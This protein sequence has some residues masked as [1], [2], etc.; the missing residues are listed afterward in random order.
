MLDIIDKM[1][2]N[3]YI[4]SSNKSDIFCI[5]CLD[6]QLFRCPEISN[7]RTFLISSQPNLK[8]KFYFMY[9]LYNI[10]KKKKIQNNSEKNY[11]F[12]IVLG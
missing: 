2:Y 10:R 7:F 3:V 8:G 12:G 5:D 11:F 6:M 1:L 4:N 9:I